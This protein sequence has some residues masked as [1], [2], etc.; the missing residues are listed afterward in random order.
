MKRRGFF[1]AIGALLTAPLLPKL[2]LKAAERIT[3]VAYD[4]SVPATDAV[5]AY[6]SALAQSMQETREVVAARV[7]NNHF[8][9]VVSP[10]LSKV[11]DDAY[12]DVPDEAA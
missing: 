6:V 11:F 5:S 3:H 1:Q 8:S 4:V 2:P 12:K 10:G 7:L 9:A